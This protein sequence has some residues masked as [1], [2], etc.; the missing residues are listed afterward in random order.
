MH[1]CSLYSRSNSFPLTLPRPCLPVQVCDLREKRLDEEEL[2]TDFTKTIEVSAQPHD[3][4][5]HPRCRLS[6]SLSSFPFTIRWVMQTTNMQLT[7]PLCLLSSP[8]LQLLRKE[9]EA[10]VKKQKVLEMG[11]S[12]IN[13]VRALFLISW[14]TSSV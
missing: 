6:L 4:A 9:K 2:I 1:V 13:Q 12:A 3:T 11:L 10:L 5:L 14:S 7:V 8:P